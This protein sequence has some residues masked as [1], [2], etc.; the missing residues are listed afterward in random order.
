MN[1]SAKVHSPLITLRLRTKNGKT[2][3]SGK[4]EINEKSPLKQTQSGH[5]ALP[6]SY[7]ALDTGSCIAKRSVMRSCAAWNGLH[8]NRC[9]A[10]IACHSCTGDWSA[11]G[12]RSCSC[13]R[14]SASAEWVREVQHLEVLEQPRKQVVVLAARQ[15]LVKPVHLLKGRFLVR[16]QPRHH[17]NVFE[18]DVFYR[19]FGV[20]PAILFDGSGYSRRW[21][22]RRRR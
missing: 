16:H 5:K 2:N 10:S 1:P 15:F 21:S 18:G 22:G 20:W 17:K 4:R 9:N 11:C 12:V 3:R 8:P 14:T 13:C 7:W 19:L 6:A